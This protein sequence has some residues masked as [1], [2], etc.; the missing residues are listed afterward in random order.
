MALLSADL[1]SEPSI[2][3][4]N[5]EKKL[6]RLLVHLN[7]WLSTCTFELYNA[8]TARICSADR[9]ALHTDT[10]WISFRSSV[11]PHNIKMSWHHCKVVTLRA[12]LSF[13]PF[14]CIV[15]TDCYFLDQ[16]T[17]KGVYYRT[18]VQLGLNYLL[19]KHRTRNTGHCVSS[20]LWPSLLFM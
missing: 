9:H 5:R 20:Q 8:E 7:L 16:I 15:A 18:L 19:G 4:T 1:N 3:W 2:S 10:H 12:K 13:S 17:S 6:C 14:D 11:H